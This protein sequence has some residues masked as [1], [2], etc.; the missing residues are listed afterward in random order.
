MPGVDALLGAAPRSS[1]RWARLRP[2]PARSRSMCTRA[3][4]APGRA[5]SGSG[6]GVVV[7]NA[8]VAAGP[9]RRGR[10]AGRTRRFRRRLTGARS[11]PA[12]SRCWRRTCELQPRC[13]PTRAGFGPASWSSPSATRS[14]WPMPPRWA[15]CTGRRAVARPRRLAACRHPAGTGQLRR[16]ARR[17]GRAG[18]GDQRDDRGGLGIAVP[19]HVIERFVHEVLSGRRRRSA[20]GVIRVLVVARSE[21]ERA[22]SRAAAGEPRVCGP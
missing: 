21:L 1:A 5:W 3:A 8:H 11:P 4:G 7:T 15:W 13:A 18:G 9:A 20:R 10:A 12:T 17:C 14:A 16:P 2:D 22:G 19:T 6:A